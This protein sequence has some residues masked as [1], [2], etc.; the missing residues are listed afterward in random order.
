MK[1]FLTAPETK[2][3]GSR[4][5]GWLAVFT[6]SVVQAAF[7]GSLSFQLSFRFRFGLGFDLRFGLL[8]ADF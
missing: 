2:R 6:Q 1:Y 3:P 8:P 5:A 4:R 7:F